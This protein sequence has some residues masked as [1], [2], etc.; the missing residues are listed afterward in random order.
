M[1][2]TAKAQTTYQLYIGLSTTVD[3]R[4]GQLGTFTF[5][6]GQYVY[7]GSAKNN[8]DARV[9]RHLSRDKKLHWHID[10]LLNSAHASILSVKRT[11]LSECTANLAVRGEIVVNR[12]GASDCRAGCGSHLKRIDSNTSAT[13][14]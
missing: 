13:S 7:T 10:Y 3:I 12:F 4:I 14:N 9:Q 2:T 6:E 11:T 5:P 1:T 8:I